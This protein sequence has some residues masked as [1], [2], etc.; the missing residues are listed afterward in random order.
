MSPHEIQ[1]VMGFITGSII[2]VAIGIVFPRRQKAYVY[3]R[4]DKGGISNSK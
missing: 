2:G 1:F 4:A 3:N